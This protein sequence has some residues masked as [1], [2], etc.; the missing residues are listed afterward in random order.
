MNYEGT[1]VHIKVADIWATRHFYENVLGLRPVYAYGD[2]E[3]GRTMPEYTSFAAEAYRGVTYKPTD[4]SFIQLTDGYV[5]DC[6]TDPFR[7]RIASPKISFML[8][9][10]SLIPFLCK[11]GLSPQLPLRHFYWGTIQMTVEDPDGLTISLVAPYSDVEAAAI[12]K[13]V[14]LVDVSCIAASPM[15]DAGHC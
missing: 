3:F 11:A 14:P 7:A 12:R 5:I 8:K 6:G 9:V 10:R 15:S 13:H 4:N 1:G 2:E